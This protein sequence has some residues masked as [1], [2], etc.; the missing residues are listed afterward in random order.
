MDTTE[1]DSVVRI[2]SHSQST[3]SLEGMTEL[4]TEKL[5]GSLRSGI[6]W[7]RLG[8]DGRLRFEPAFQPLPNPT[9]DLEMLPFWRKTSHVGLQMNLRLVETGRPSEK[10]EMDDSPSILIQHLC[11]YNY[12]PEFYA[13]TAR[14]LESY[15]FNC[16]RSKRANDGMYWE[17]WFLPGLWAATGDFATELNRI[18][19]NGRQPIKMAL[20]FLGR[21]VSFG[22][23]DVSI[24]RMA[25]SID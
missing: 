11:G 20:K 7:T 8:D 16:M 21:K 19:G 18:K 4:E 6:Y 24:Q 15:G 10:L 22:T 9:E 5:Q 1:T 13:S 17:I 14:Q 25:M 12:T 3:L 23:L 2:T